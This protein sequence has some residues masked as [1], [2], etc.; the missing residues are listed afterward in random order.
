MQSTTR[1]SAQGN[2]KC[3]VP[4]VFALLVTSC[5]FVAS[6]CWGVLHLVA[7]EV[8]MDPGCRGRGGYGG[9]YRGEG[10]QGTFHPPCHIQHYHMVLALKGLRT[11]IQAVEAQVLA[12][13]CVYKN[14]A[15]GATD[16]TPSI[17]SDVQ[18]SAQEGCQPSQ[19]KLGL[20]FFT[21]NTGTVK[22]P[23]VAR[24]ASCCGLFQTREVASESYVLRVRVTPTEHFALTLE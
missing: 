3:E 12:Y 4:G 2:C 8:A 19:Q 15:A 21:D 16:G 9:G 6:G 1:N 10:G 13:R 14:G 24:D 17:I 20:S 5:F 23:R 18:S 7:R 22:A 11:M